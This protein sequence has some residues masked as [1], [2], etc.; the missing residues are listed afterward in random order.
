M[1]YTAPVW[2][3]SSIMEE[4]RGIVG[5]PDTGMLSNQQCADLINW[6]Y[7]YVLPKEL[8]IFWGYTK[9]QFFCQ[10]NVDQYIAPTGFQTLN[11][12]VY[13][14]GF[15]IEWY[16]D[17]D[18][19]YQDW[20]EQMNKQQVATADGTNNSFS[21]SISAYPV[22]RRS[23]YVTDG[24]QVTQ[25]NG[26]GGFIDSVTGLAVSGTINY[27]TGAVSG[28]VFPVVPIANADI[29]ATSQTY[30]ANRPQS[31]LF[32]RQDQYANSTVAVR[33]AVNMFVIRPVPDEVYKI[34]LQGIQIPKPFVN[35]TDVPF[36]PDLGPLIALGAALQRFKRLNQMDQYDQY[37]PEYNRF[38]DICMQD[39]YEELIYERSISSF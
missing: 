12:S 35:D 5:V 27:E 28:L 15:P 30:M 3:F 19:F 29:T 10:A 6:Y 16:I 21:F 22:L 37:L 32:F 9:Y 7:Q 20:P 13:A 24:T 34:S 2:N 11:P 25:D 1:V 38:K 33:D 23:V 39:T 4:F 31:I 26:T 17:P 8:K 18:T 14:D 36:R